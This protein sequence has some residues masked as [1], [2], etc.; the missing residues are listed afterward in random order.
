MQLTWQLEPVSIL[1]AASES[2]RFLANS[3]VIA[4]VFEERGRRADIRNSKRWTEFPARYG[5]RC[6]F[7]QR[8]PR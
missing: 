7:F 1:I 6:K 4:F 8:R 3:R 5:G 2:P